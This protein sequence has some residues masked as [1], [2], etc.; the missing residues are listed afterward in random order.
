MTR[1]AGSS[2]IASADRWGASADRWGASADRW[3]VNASAVV[4]SLV[5]LAAS[6]HA[7]CPDGPACVAE[8]K[9]LEGLHPGDISGALQ[10]YARACDLG[11]MQGCDEAARLYDW[12]W[13]WAGVN[14]DV[15]KSLALYRKACD[16]SYFAACDSL[17]LLLASGDGVTHDI[18][19][20]TALFRKAC[21]G[22]AMHGCTSL[23]Y[24][25]ERG[26]G[27]TADLGKARALYMKACDGGDYQGCDNTGLLDVGSDDKN[28]LVMFDRGCKLES[29]YGCMRAADLYRA[30][31]RTAEATER[32]RH[33]CRRNETSAC[34]SY[35]ELSPGKDCMQRALTP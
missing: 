26:R 15:D 7:A 10:A 32:Y 2:S 6:A 35:C 9:R 17:G 25:Y 23:G 8:G 24:G 28:A 30:A 14:R 11:A 21:D 13:S 31:H 3:G 12:G 27:V 29:G 4:A 5:G 18:A 22:G 33:A 20:A 1:R 16:G 34:A 19:A